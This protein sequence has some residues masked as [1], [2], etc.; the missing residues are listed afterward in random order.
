MEQYSRSN[1]IEINEMPEIENENCPNTVINIARE[2]KIDLDLC[3]I[4]FAHRV[5]TKS[6]TSKNKPPPIIVK[7]LSKRKRDE[8]MS[9]K[10]IIM[11]KGSPNE[12]KVYINEHISPTYKHLLMITKHLAK[13]LSYKYVW[14][15][16]D[17]VLVRKTENS[18]IIHIESE[19]DLQ[20][21]KH[22]TNLSTTLANN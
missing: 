2:L 1:N 19:K 4:D 13:D 7:F 14:F 10:Y 20:K 6:T 5:P 21:L 17:K 18:P 9:K 3:E 16:K 12:K 11:F 8:F 15:R 22:T